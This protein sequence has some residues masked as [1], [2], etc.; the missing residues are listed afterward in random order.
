[1]NGGLDLTLAE[2]LKATHPSGQDIEIEG[3]WM[4]STTTGNDKLPQ[5]QFS[6]FALSEFVSIIPKMPNLEFTLGRSGWN[7]AGP[8]HVATDAPQELLLLKC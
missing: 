2:Q 1:V 6:P 3:E 7:G 4:A 5:L 8:E